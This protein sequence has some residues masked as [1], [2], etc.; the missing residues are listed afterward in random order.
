MARKHP[1]KKLK[2]Y[3]DQQKYFQEL[4]D[5]HLNSPV[6][7]K[8]E[9]KSKVK[10]IIF[11][12]DIKYGFIGEKFLMR[13][14]LANKLISMGRAVDY[15]PENRLKFMPQTPE[16]KQELA[17]KRRHMNMKKILQ[18]MILKFQRRTSGHNEL[19]IPITR[20]QICNQIWKQQKLILDPDVIVDW[21]GDIKT[22]G[23]YDIKMDIGEPWKLIFR[24]EVF[25]G[26]LIDG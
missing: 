4:L 11:T 2:T 6:V 23:H 3:Q 18:R 24:V 17:K 1:L 19:I 13:R 15:S 7:N 25:S 26:P 22:P 9:L 16:A 5:K 14:P 10:P 8:N 20:Y 21:K 12:K